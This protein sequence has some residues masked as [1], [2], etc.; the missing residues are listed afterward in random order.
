MFDTERRIHHSVLMGRMA[1]AA[2]ADLGAALADGRLSVPD[3]VAMLGR[4][5]G[6]QAAPECE[7]WLDY[8]PVRAPALPGYCRN[9]DR[10]AGLAAC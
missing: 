10:L 4:C 6:C 8:N 2:G 9:R 3:L 1:E 7:V 5:M